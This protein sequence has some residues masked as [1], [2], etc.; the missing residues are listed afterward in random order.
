MSNVSYTIRIGFVTASRPWNSADAG[1]P[2]R[3]ADTPLAEIER[4]M[5]CLHEAECCDLCDGHGNIRQPKKRGRH[6]KN[7]AY[8]SQIRI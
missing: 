1:N 5:A 3:K 4:C 6:R 7:A 8:Q 2:I